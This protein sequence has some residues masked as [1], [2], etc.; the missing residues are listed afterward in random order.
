MSSISMFGEKTR[1]WLPLPF[2]TQRRL[3]VQ[4]S[5]KHRANYP[6]CLATTSPGVSWRRSWPLCAAEMWTKSIAKW[7][8]TGGWSR[9]ERGA[10]SESFFQIVSQSVRPCVDWPNIDLEWQQDLCWTIHTCILSQKSAMA[11]IWECEMGRSLPFTIRH[12]GL[13]LLNR[14]WP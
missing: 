1:Y 8:S 4:H 9:R 7:E 2:C 14:S 3:H 13:F 5:P 12:F 10:K 6:I 11:H